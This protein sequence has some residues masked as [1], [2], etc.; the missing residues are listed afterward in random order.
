MSLT[1]RQFEDLYREQIDHLDLADGTRLTRDLLVRYISAFR[2][3]TGDDGAPLDS[4]WQTIARFLRGPH[5]APDLT[6]LA[7]L[8]EL[9]AAIKSAE[10]N[11]DAAIRRSA[12]RWPVESTAYATAL[13]VQR[14]YQIRTTP[15]KKKEPRP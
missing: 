9:A 8:E 11:R 13:S 12:K 7:E 6:E 14:I 5:G 4:Q 1:P 15:P 3:K 2:I 10:E